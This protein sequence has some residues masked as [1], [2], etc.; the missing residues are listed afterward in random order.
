MG[1]LHPKSVTD[2]TFKKE[3][4]GGGREKGVKETRQ[5][6][7]GPIRFLEIKLLIPKSVLTTDS[8]SKFE[9][10]KE[11]QVSGRAHKTP[12]PE[13]EPPEV[14]FRAAG[15]SLPNAEAL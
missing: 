11:P 1:L 5:D 15:L 7:M 4:G 3:G 2:K 10:P 9:P 8:Y 12:G 13:E 14:R 6:A